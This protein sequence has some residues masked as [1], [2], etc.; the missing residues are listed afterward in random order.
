M[1]TALLS[2][3]VVSLC[4]VSSPVVAQQAPLE[5]QEKSVIRFEINMDRII[6]SELGKNLD[7]ATKMQ[8]APG[9]DTEEMD[10]SSITKVYGSLSL[11][12]NMEAFQSM[13]PGSELP[14]ELFSRIEFSESATLTGVM[15][16]MAEKAEEVSLGGK[17]YLKP[18]DGDSP[19]GMLAQK[20]D[21]KTLEMGTEKY[22]TRSDREVNTDGLNKAWGMAPDHAIR[23]AVD[24]DGMEALKEELIDFVAQVQ[25]QAIAYVE[26]LNN[27]S[28]LRITVDLDSD[29]LLTICA[30]G[31]DEELAEEFADGLDSLLMFGKMGL[32]P[33]NAPTDEAAAVMKEI[34]DAMEAKLDGK[35]VSIRIP[36]PEGF[37]AMV[38]GMVPPGF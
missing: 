37:N 35:E 19:P 7:L 12:D 20:I 2:L 9:I 28:N 6:N 18:T 10:P 23:I 8:E 24:V 21:D 31:K 26:L 16:K 27:V 25:P 33:A 30:T 17:T 15:E 13:T 36:R 34:S 3:A 32:N 4:L 5:V 22:V 1:R 38:E 14:M 11:P 29:E